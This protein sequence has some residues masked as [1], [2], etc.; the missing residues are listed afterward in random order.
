MIFY[1]F[2]FSSRRRHTRCALVT[3]VQTCALPIARIKVRV[4][5]RFCQV[6]CQAQF[7]RPCF[8]LNIGLSVS[9]VSDIVGLALVVPIKPMRG[10]FSHLPETLAYP[11]D[12]EA[13]D[14]HPTTAVQPTLDR[15]R[16]VWGKS[17]SVGG[18]LGLCHR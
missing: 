5:I 14:A 1:V 7:R 12:D 9:D 11:Y 18:A 17:V 4:N 8:Q 3:G 2:F 15:T 10:L 6:G 13:Q 16:V